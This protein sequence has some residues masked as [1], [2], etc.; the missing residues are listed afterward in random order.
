MAIRQRIVPIAAAAAALAG[1]CKEEKIRSYKVPEKL[2]VDRTD[3]KPSQPSQSVE[4]MTRGGPAASNAPTRPV[5]PDQGGGSGEREPQAAD[6][7]PSL[8][9]EPPDG[10][11]KKADTGSMRFAAFRAGAN[12]KVSVSVTPLQ[13]RG[14]GVLRNVNRWR[15]QIGLGK[16]GRSA[17]KKR[18]EVVPVGKQS[19]LFVDL[20]GEGENHAKRIVAAVVPRES[21]TWFFKMRGPSKAVAKQVE[22]FRS[23][24]QAVRFKG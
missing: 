5:R 8:T 16:I 11:E 4:A 21:R 23:F 1:G 7:G 6:G 19:G 18:A 9:L 17:L 3:D 13:G 20:G 22:A 12:K 2:A 15:K 24:L 10:W 14:G